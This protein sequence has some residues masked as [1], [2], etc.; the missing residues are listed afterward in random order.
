[1][2]VISPYL[3]FFFFFFFEYFF[4]MFVKN[5]KIEK[6]FFFFFCSDFLPSNIGAKWGRYR[7]AQR[8]RER[9]ALSLENSLHSAGTRE[10]SSA[11]SF[12]FFVKHD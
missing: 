10:E 1:V 3:F 4:L 12:F 9:P 6:A 2:Y 7:G 5:A 8:E 11:F